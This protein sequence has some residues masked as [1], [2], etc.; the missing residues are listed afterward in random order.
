MIEVL[1]TN[2][3]VKLSYAMSVLSDAGCDPFEAD[4]YTASVEGSISAIPRRILVPDDQADRARGL[5]AAL[6]ET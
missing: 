4:R 5:L 3:P 1:R 6:D 2:D